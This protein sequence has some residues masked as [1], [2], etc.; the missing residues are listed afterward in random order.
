MKGGLTRQFLLNYLIAFV[1]SILAA[2]FA[3]L[4]MSF[5]SDVLSK[6]LMKNQYPASQLM[7][8]DYTQ[9]D[10]G[11][12]VL[13][14]GGLQ[15]VDENFDVVVSASIDPFQGGPLT[16]GRFTD[17]LVHSH[18]TGTPYHYDI[19]YNQNGRF[20]LVVTF[21][22]SI[23]LDFALVYNRETASKDIGN[24]SASLVAVGVF[25]LLLLAA[26]AAVFSRI[27]S[28][29]IVGPLRKLTEGTRRLREGDYTAR[30]NLNPKNEFAELQDTFNGMAARIESEISLREQSEQERK[31][32]IL[33][34]SHDL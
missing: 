22:T 7:R 31:R 10:A 6:T 4:L 3:V 1:L 12:V 30:V 13:N 11:P 20:W 26:F 24:V 8:E 17:F 15:V 29:H 14:G 33:D 2:F 9:I 27:T 16:T 25:Y 19:A 23:R 21:P 32:L 34:V 18:A 5:A 28:R